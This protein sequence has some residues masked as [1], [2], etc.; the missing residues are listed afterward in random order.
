MPVRFAFPLPVDAAVGSG[1]CP[2]QAAWRPVLL[3]ALSACCSSVRQML[4]MPTLKLAGAAL[5]QILMPEGA[6]DVPVGVPMF[7]VVEDAADVAGAP[8]ASQQS[9]PVFPPLAYTRPSSPWL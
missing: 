9:T 3:V 6:T 8:P 2:L 1:R 7:V 4:T 5:M